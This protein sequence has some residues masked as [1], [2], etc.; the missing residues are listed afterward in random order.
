MRI[1]KRQIETSALVVFLIAGA[2]TIKLGGEKVT[3]RVGQVSL[4][5]QIDGTTLGGMSSLE[6]FLHG[7]GLRSG[8]TWSVTPE[9]VTNGYRLV[10]ETAACAIAEP[11][12]AA[13]T[14]WLWM[15][16]GAYEDA[17]AIQTANWTFRIPSGAASNLLVFASGRMTMRGHEELV[18]PRAFDED[19][20]ILPMSRWNRIQD[21]ASASAFWH[22][23]TPSNTLVVTWVNALLGRNIASNATFQAEFYPNGEF[24]YRHADETRRYCVLNAFDWDGDGLA[25]EIDPDPY[26]NSGDCHGTC[27]GWYNANCSN[28]LSATA[29]AIGETV[30]TWNTNA[31]PAAYYWLDFAVTGLTGVAKIN[32]TCDGPSNLGDMTVVALTNQGCRV[33]LLAGAT[34]AIDSTLPLES[35]SAASQYAVVESCSARSATVSLPLAFSFAP[36]STAGSY[37]LASSPLPVG[38]N[39][40]TIVGGC[41][42]CVPNGGGFVWACHP[43]C[44]CIG[45]SHMF[46]CTAAWEGYSRTFPWEESCECQV[47]RSINPGEWISLSV[48]TV[49][50]AGAT[51][52]PSALSVGFDPPCPTNGT[53]TL[54]AIGGASRI[55]L[56]EAGGLAATLPQQWNAEMFAGASFAIEGVLQS[57]SARD[58]VFE[59]EYNEPA[60]G[61]HSVTQSMTVARVLRVQMSSPVA[62]TS[63]NPPPF[64]GETSCP[65]SVT[66]SFNPDRHLVIPFCNVVDTNANF[67]VTD[68]AVNMLVELAPADTPPGA[69]HAAWSVLGGTPQSGTLSAAGALSADYLNPKVGGVYRFSVTCN[70]SPATECNLVLPLSGAEVVGDIVNDLVVADVKIDILTNKYG[71]VQRQ[72][73]FNGRRW[74]VKHGAGD[75]L[76]RPDNCA[77]Q[78]VWFYNQ[79]NDET[80]MGACATLAGVPI[81]VAKLSNFFVGYCA[82]KIDVSEMAKFVSQGIGTG[83]DMSSTLAWE[84]GGAVA[85]GSNYWTIVSNLVR[86]AWNK[87]DGNNERLWPNHCP[88]DNKVPPTLV[89]PEWNFRFTEPYFLHFTTK[90]M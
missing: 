39:L 74:F 31:N 35:I 68:F 79:V 61:C 54:R 66:N 87:S 33:P 20:S 8:E 55:A 88:L 3:N 53:V 29:N 76:G 24:E 28:V 13:V 86:S 81:R 57:E 65:F 71:W 89:Y 15:K 22:E 6:P 18:L 40:A 14:N 42:D 1:G 50:F 73:P 70:G 34:Y 59:L 36:M 69:V 49:V 72:S 67:G 47:Q 64:V 52:W 27:V 80:G 17:F 48:P 12:A 23:V 56:Y 9:D 7:N 30:I 21:G 43:E 32:I 46:S 11:T 41:C 2:A 83:N 90:G 62:G 51:N 16:R 84:A 26:A 58:V 78:T 25:N 38:A 19:V 5:G 82:T 37:E 85:S 44:S 10:S 63:P 45:Y 75:Y 77:S 60:S 4:P